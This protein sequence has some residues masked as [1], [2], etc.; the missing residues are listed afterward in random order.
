MRRRQLPVHSPITLGALCG[1]AAAGLSL[2]A[3]PRQALRASLLRDY[4]ADDVVLCRSGTEALQ[5]GIRAAL[6]QARASAVALPAF[7]CFDVGAAAVGV[8]AAIELY[9]VQ[10]TT[11]APDLDSLERVLR[12]GARVVVVAPLY[13]VPV[14]W[15]AM[16]AVLEPHGAVAV[17]D[18]A[19]GHG[20]SWRDDRLG[21]LGPISVL[22]FGR[23]KGWTGGGGGA[24]LLRG[25]DGG[26]SVGDLIPVARVVDEVA[27]LHR[28]TAHWAFGRPA[29]YA[30]PAALPWLRLGETVY[31]TATP[32][33]L[34]SRTAAAVAHAMAEEAQREA[35]NRRN[36][37]GCLL[38]AV[39]DAATGIWAIQVHPQA[40]P[41]F[42]R[43]PVRCRHGLGGFPSP[44]EASRLGIAAS[45]PS[46]LAALPPIRRALLQ[47][48]SW[49]G[50]DELA[51]QLCTL[52]THTRLSPAERKAIVAQ[53]RGYACLE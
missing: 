7:T 52:P 45:Y 36:N 31:R 24:L 40:T 38:D 49:P 18:A 50:A 22:S 6:R 35:V 20:A 53:V 29:L 21:S 11:L 51:R 4:R 37:A 27:T 14:N 16:T 26:N 46:S 34:M 9:D 48:G 23:G 44:A 8:G 17:E 39:R 12:R 5:L 33:R 43:L 1:A 47:T 15:D 2:K 28:A 42:L 3:D 41:S 30:I 13:G 25:V 32:P 10:P 19:Q